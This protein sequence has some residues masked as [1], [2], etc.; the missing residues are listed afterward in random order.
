LP[1]FAA[2]TCDGALQQAVDEWTWCWSHAAL[3]PCYSRRSTQ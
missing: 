1:H 3:P 2:T